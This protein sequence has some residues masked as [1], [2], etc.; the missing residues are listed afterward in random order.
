MITVKK[1]N[2]LEYLVSSEISVPHA[3]TTRFGGVSTGFLSSLNLTVGRGDT[4]E[5]VEEN[6]RIL[7]RGVGFDPE[8]LVLT[9]QIHSDLVRVVT[10]ADC[11]GLCHQVYPQ[12]DGLVTNT[13]GLSLMVFTADCTPLL[14]WDPVTGAV[15][16]AH[17]GWR[18]TAQDI[19]G[20]TVQ[21]MQERFGSRPEDIRAAVGPNIGPCH[22]ETNADV[23]EALCAAFGRDAEMYIQTRGGKFF[24]DLK[25][26]NAMALRRRGV[27]RIE[28]S[29]ECT[30][31]S[32]DRFWSHRATAG[33][34]G[35]QGA[36]ITCR[37][38]CR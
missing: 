8:R 25:A 37:G 21:A 10:E 32:T 14:L 35:S 19:A 36:V 4:M 1:Q 3:F 2:T 6:I 29:T 31:C 28:V 20:K 26:I 13:P 7:S 22:F 33:E 5:N 9:R 12:C 23:P 18:G 24:P 15:G 34:R 16:A 11:L 38:V 17:A 30:C 27:T